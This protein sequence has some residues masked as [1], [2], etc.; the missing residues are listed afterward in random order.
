[1]CQCSLM[2]YMNYQRTTISDHFASSGCRRTCADYAFIA[3]GANMHS[4]HGDPV[5]SIRTAFGQLAGLSD[6]TMLVSSMWRTPPRDCPP[7]SPDFVNAA[8]ALVPRPGQSAH[9]LLTQLQDIEQAFGRQAPRGRA[10]NAPRPLDLDIIEFCGRR[11]TDEVLTIPHPRAHE[12]LFVLAPLAEIAPDLQL[13]G[14]DRSI[15]EMKCTIPTPNGFTR[16]D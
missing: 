8:A 12:R 7:G 1:M 15:C 2:P 11:L 9:G 5:Q 6:E 13:A 10:R 14:A 3:L 4:V 16:I